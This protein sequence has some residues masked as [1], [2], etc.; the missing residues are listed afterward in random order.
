MAADQDEQRCG[1]SE[2][3][4]LAQQ[5]RTQNVTQPGQPVRM[6]YCTPSPGACVTFYARACV[7]V[8]APTGYA[9]A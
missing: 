8:L 7:A 3:I 5:V 1:Q 4:D 9:A 6:Y 2:L